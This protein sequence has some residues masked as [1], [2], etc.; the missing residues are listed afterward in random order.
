MHSKLPSID[1]PVSGL[2]S[3]GGVGLGGNVDDDPANR[4]SAEQGRVCN[5]RSSSIKVS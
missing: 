5:H 2:F 4:L 1:D 3:D